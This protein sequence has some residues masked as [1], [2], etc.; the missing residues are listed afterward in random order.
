MILEFRQRKGGRR[1]EESDGESCGFGMSEAI[2]EAGNDLVVLSSNWTRYCGEILGSI[3]MST[4]VPERGISSLLEFG[5]LI[6]VPGGYG[7]LID[8]VSPRWSET[9][10]PRCK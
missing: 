9:K 2:L 3:G 7:S 6:R 5:S 8:G 1:W 4:M 10:R